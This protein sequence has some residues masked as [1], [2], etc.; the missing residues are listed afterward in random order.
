MHYAIR[1]DGDRLHWLEVTRLP[2]AL[3]YFEVPSPPGDVLHVNVMRN[4]PADL[5]VLT[6]LGALS[7]A[8]SGEAPPVKWR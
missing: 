6:C 3:C 2:D 1:I 8:R 7:L 5:V 4:A